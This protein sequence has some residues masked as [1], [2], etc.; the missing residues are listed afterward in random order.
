MKT[1]QTEYPT[2][3]ARLAQ[4]IAKRDRDKT[5]WQIVPSLAAFIVLGFLA[6]W[7]P[8]SLTVPTPRP[9]SGSLRTK[10]GGCLNAVACP[11]IGG[12]ANASS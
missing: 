10:E 8:G 5:R 6:S 9:G 11:S 12:N 7:L 4:D 2:D 3:I 1:A